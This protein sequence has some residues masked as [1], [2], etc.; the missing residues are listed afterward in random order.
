MPT[1]R[2]EM[3]TESPEQIG[4][5]IGSAVGFALLV[6]EGAKSNTRGNAEYLLVLIFGGIGW[7]CGYLVTI[8]VALLH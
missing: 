6:Y 5:L 2:R 3:Q 7:C 8:L 1:W 4:F